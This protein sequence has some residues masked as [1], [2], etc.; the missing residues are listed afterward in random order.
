MRSEEFLVGRGQ[1]GRLGLNAGMMQ[2]LDFASE[3]ACGVS[4]LLGGHSVHS[5]SRP[6]ASLCNAPS[7]TS[8][9]G[10]SH[11]QNLGQIPI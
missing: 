5:P 11:S 2:G 1:G 7:S 8:H 4:V 3:V 6:Y 9:S 10:P